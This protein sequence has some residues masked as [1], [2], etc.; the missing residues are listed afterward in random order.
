MPYATQR[1]IRQDPCGAAG[2][3]GNGECSLGYGGVKL[4]ELRKLTA[5]ELTR[6]T[7]QEWL[8]ARYMCTEADTN[9]SSGPTRGSPTRPGLSR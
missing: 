8:D 5:G 3:A 2:S 9:G 7:Y 6:E 1:G 4:E